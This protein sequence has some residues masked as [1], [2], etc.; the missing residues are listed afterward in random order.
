MGAY[1]PNQRKED[2][3][4]PPPAVEQ[5]PSLT[6]AP[7]IRSVVDRFEDLAVGDDPASENL[8]QV[9]RA[10]EDAESTIKQQM[11][12]NNQL[13]EELMRRT[14]ELQR[15]RLEAAL[16]SNPNPNPNPINT[17]SDP[18]SPVKGNGP[19]PAPSLTRSIVVRQNASQEEN[20]NNNNNNINSNNNN[21]NNGRINNN[22][23][24]NNNGSSKKRSGTDS[25]GPSRISTP[26]SRSLSPTRHRKEGESDERSNSSG[27]RGLVPVSEP[28]S[29]LVWKQDLAAKVR[30]HEEEIF[31]LRKHLADYSV[32]EAQI[33][34]EK[35]VLEKRIAYMRMAF[36]KQ[37]QDLVDAA[38]KALSYRQDIIEENIRLT[39]ALQAA[40]QERSTFVSSLL[41]LLQEYN[42]QPS[43][44][45]AQS[46][47]SHLKMLF[48]HLQ[49]KLIITEEKLKE[50]QYQITP[51]N[52]DY[53][54]NAGLPPPSPSHQKAL[55]PS[56][57]MEI[58]PQQMYASQQSPTVQAHSDWDLP[59][60]PSRQNLGPAAATSSS[61]QQVALVGD[62]HV[63]SS[64]ELREQNLS[65]K[66]LARGGGGSDVLEDSG[67][68]LSVSDK[69]GPAHISP[70]DNNNN[71]NNNNNNVN[72]INSGAAD[73]ANNPFPYLPTVMEEPSSSFSEAAEDD[74]L[75]AIEGLRI[76]GEAFPG[77]E[78]QAS[79]Y[80][81]NGT[82]S[83]N[84]EW[85]RHHEDGSVNYIDGAKQPNYLV[86]ADDVDAYLAIEVQPLDERKRKGELVKFFANDQK[87]IT[88]DTET[89]DLIKKNL[90]VGHV[91]YEVELSARF[92]DIWE[93]AVL[94]IKR[95]GYSIKCSG[96]RGIV[97]QDKFQQNTSINIPFGQATDFII[98]SAD[99]VDYTL[100]PV[101]TGVPRDIIVLTLR[102]FKMMAVEK[103]KGKK[104]GLFFKLR[105]LKWKHE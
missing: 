6:R 92:M 12:E 59:G 51:L 100:K 77:R 103:R 22:N 84:F 31:Q 66:D 82:T 23:N 65:F 24:N 9:M 5:A 79:G 28:S 55:V 14:H 35:S 49:E 16:R 95:E 32:K 62:P 30:E 47:V 17:E 90:S 71:S 7:G 29:N 96:P 18:N 81:I 48:R 67:R 45:D 52:H 101:E 3:T 4:P 50:S 58:V 25:G 85:V 83:C 78:L 27:Q 34:H 102:L 56:N 75:P 88:C 72:N 87:K 86:T 105:D 21:Y 93:P 42:L 37:Q 74:P 38:S 69:W 36:D 10:V 20:N 80:S 53:S 70:N 41:P 73:D 13:K 15:V 76:S 2:L 46:I 57:S 60:H 11:E 1:D 64:L 54:N 40:Q 91:S 43:V 104:R 99:G 63:R 61:S 39:Y 97:V 68:D 94:S 26:S 44:H 33:L 89:Q 8:F 98:Q 19:T